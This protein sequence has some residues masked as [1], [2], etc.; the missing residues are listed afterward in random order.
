MLKHTLK[1]M[2]LAVWMLLLTAVPI[3]TAQEQCGVVSSVNFPV[4]IAQF[5]IAQDF[6][7]P[8]IR[9]QGRYHTGED[10]YGGRGTSEGH[11]V[12]AIAAGRVTYS[13]PDGWGRDRG[14]IIIQHTFPDKS[15]AYSMYGHLQETPTYPFPKRYTCVKPGDIIGV[16][17]DIRPVPHVHFEIRVNQPDVPGPGYLTDVPTAL[18]WRHPSQFV[19]N[20]QTWLGPAHRWHTD[21]GDESGPLTPP[22]ELPDHQMLYLDSNRV[23]GLTPDGRVLWRTNLTQPALALT[24]WQDEPLLTYAD[25]TMQ[26]I[27]VDGTLGKSWQTGMR[28]DSPPLIAGKALLFHTPDNVLVA[29]NAE[30]QAAIWQLPNVPAWTRAFAAPNA[31]GLL[32]CD[33]QLLTVSLTGKLLDH[34]QL[35][36]PAGL[37]AALN[38]DLLVYGSGGLW[39]VN[40][41]GQ[42]TMAMENV[43]SGGMS[44]NALFTPDGKS[45]LFDGRTFYAYN[46][47]QSPR[48]QVDIPNVEGQVQLARYD[49]VILLTSSYGSITAVQ[50]STGAVC[51]VAR[52][53]GDRRSDLWHSRGDDRVLRVVVAGQV[54]GLDWKKFIGACG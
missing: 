20:W 42:W 10:W 25:G 38:G 43:P 28:L 14:V 45:Y 22:L 52:V 53:Y 49:N 21:M 27:G 24:W 26:Q 30:R 31:I 39:R 36:E 9:H 50:E 2:L 15:I 7:A 47:D 51:N 44:A 12:H 46:P 33:N 41:N 8:S 34:A 40:G 11:P 54:L 5:R 3:S 19:L 35:R 1:M 4:D 29:F 48:W 37:G 6:A 23:R 16:I 32:T 18:G 17:A 13:A